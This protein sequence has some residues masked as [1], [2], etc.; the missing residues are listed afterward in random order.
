MENQNTEGLF[1]FSIVITDN[2]E[3]QSAELLVSKFAAHSFISITYCVEPEQN[4]ALARNKSLEYATGDFIVFIDDDEVPEKEWLLNL[5]HTCINSKVD[6]VLG[7]VKPYFEHN[8]P[9]WIV[10]GKFFERPTHE[11]GFRIGLSDARTG[12]FLFRR[13]ILKG[14][15]EVF[16]PQYATGGEDVNFFRKMMKKGCVFI[17]CNDAVVNE[18]VPPARSNC[19]YLLRSALLRGNNSIKNQPDLGLILKSLAAIP[20][21]TILLPVLY[22]IGFHWFMRYMIKLCDHSGRILAIL[23][24]NPVHTRKIT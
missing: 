21:Y 5:F 8:P 12:N 3:E 18:L 19:R 15:A 11:T 23:G 1:T 6:G 10:K 13:D 16:S 17:W 2:D 9:K 24:M 7:P 14:I 22:I 4:I 20:I